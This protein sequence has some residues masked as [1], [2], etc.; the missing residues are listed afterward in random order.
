MG[1]LIVLL[2]RID[3]FVN[4]VYHHQFNISN[5]YRAHISKGRPGIAA[6]DTGKRVASSNS[7]Y[8]L[9]VKET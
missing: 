4:D 6:S 8:Q 5:T 9:E 2:I 7:F 3:R 1:I